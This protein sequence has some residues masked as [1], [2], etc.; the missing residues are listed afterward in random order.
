MKDI[1][2]Y[3]SWSNNTKRL[4]EAINQEL[5]DDVVRIERKNPYS[6]DIINV[7]MLKPKKK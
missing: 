4:V 1:I 2:V 6:T 5:K 3:F 7:L